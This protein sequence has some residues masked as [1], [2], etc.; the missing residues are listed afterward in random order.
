M[1]TA[2]AC[3]VAAELAFATATAGACMNTTI[4]FIIRLALVGIADE[5]DVGKDGGAEDGEDAL[6]GALEELATRL[7][8]FVVCFLFH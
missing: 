7:Q 4:A 1:A 8:L 3:A 2:L 6:G 5:G